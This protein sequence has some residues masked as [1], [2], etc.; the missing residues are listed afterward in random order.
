MHSRI[1]PSIEIEVAYER[2]YIYVCKCFAVTAREKFYFISFIA[3]SNLIIKQQTLHLIVAQEG[4]GERERERER[5][6]ANE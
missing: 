4:E 2:V 5:E 1:N 6:R 3:N